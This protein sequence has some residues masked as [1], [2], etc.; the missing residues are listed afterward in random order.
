M[1]E[2]IRF[3]QGI[4]EAGQ[5]LASLKGGFRSDKTKIVDEQGGSCNAYPT[6]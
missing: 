2:L 1:V 4:I 6:H 5:K 3:R